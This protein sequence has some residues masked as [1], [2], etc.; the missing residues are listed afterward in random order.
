MVLETYRHGILF[1]KILFSRGFR[2]RWAKGEKWK[3]WT[4]AKISV[5]FLGVILYISCKYIYI[6]FFFVK[7]SAGRRIVL[8]ETISVTEKFKIIY[9]HGVARGFHISQRY[10]GTVLRSLL[11]VHTKLWRKTERK[12]ERNG[13]NGKKKKKKNEELPQLGNKW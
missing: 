9:L 3:L 12:K 5:Y 4:E 13:G 6:F 2:Q 11:Y 8:L 1:S 10:C 7:S